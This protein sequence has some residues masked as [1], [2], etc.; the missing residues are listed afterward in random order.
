MIKWRSSVFKAVLVIGLVYSQNLSAEEF[1]SAKVLEWDRSA[2]NSLFQSSITMIG[3][4]AAQM[5]EKSHIAR[6]ID[7]W[8]AADSI[9]KRQDQI[10]NAMAR[11]PTYHPQ[12]VI[13]AVVEK[14]CGKFER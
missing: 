12:A 7:Q 1:A 9:E 4:V 11:F 13:L 14:A 8:Y 3:I 2:Q 5:E 6:C 10:R